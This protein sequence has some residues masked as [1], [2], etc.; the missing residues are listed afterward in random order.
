MRTTETKVF[1]ASGQKDM[2]E[3]RMKVC[4]MLWGAGIEVKG[5][6]SYIFIIYGCFK[7]DRIILQKG[8]IIFK[9][10]PVL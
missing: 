3:E 5:K 4:N 7:T 8:S 10:S 1:V 6:A 2:L 9:P